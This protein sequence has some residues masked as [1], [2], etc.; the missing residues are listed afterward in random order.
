LTT[1]GSAAIVCAAMMGLLCLDLGQDFKFRLVQR[2]SYCSIAARRLNG[3]IAS[4]LTPRSEPPIFRRTAVITN[5]KTN[6]FVR[7]R[8]SVSPFI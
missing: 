3:C 6:H 4:D 5:Q 7:Y 8:F 1:M 2:L